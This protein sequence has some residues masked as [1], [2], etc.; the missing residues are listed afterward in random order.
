VISPHRAR[1][2][3]V[4]RPRRDHYR[5]T[6]SE[7]RPLLRRVTERF[8]FVLVPAGLLFIAL[9]PIG[10]FYAFDFRVFWEA[11][12]SFVDGE[13]P[14]P[15]QSAAVIASKQNFLYPA[16]IA[17]LF[18]P[19]SVVPFDVAAVLFSLAVAAAPI[20][21]L[22]LLGLRDWRCYGAVF[23][24]LPL[25]LSVSLGTISTFL[26][27][28]VAVLWRYRDKA[29]VA[30]PVLALLVVS[31]LFLWP[32]AF[33]FVAT[34]RWRTAVLAGVLGGA[35]SLVAWWQ[36]GL[37]TLRVYPDLLRLVAE[38]EQA[39]SFSPTALGIALGVPTELAQFG[40][41]ALGV[42]LLAAAGIRVRMRGN[43]FTMLVVALAAA[44][45][46]SPIVWGH[47]LVLLFVPLAIAR[48][49]F[50]VLWLVTAWMTPDNL[51]YGSDLA[52]T[53]ATFC[54]LIAIAIVLVSSLRAKRIVSRSE[55]P[56]PP[57][58]AQ[59]RPAPAPATA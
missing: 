22:Y 56:T 52:A 49:T 50:G 32:L 14:Y 16:P 9:W 51:Q 48:P 45:V 36:V 57:R 39:D 17:A 59:A 21:M 27:L 24:G 34:R 40:S 31:K 23:L 28:G 18:A 55:S 12:R 29:L 35:A 54:G 13:S 4:W 25:A 3:L 30:A 42:G 20:L 58:D 10:E 41:L 11:G 33:W 46:C 53:I 43:D 8:V 37:E 38:V 26:G 2:I 7:V 19:L 5:V 1:R 6:R 44:L 15:E 47:Y